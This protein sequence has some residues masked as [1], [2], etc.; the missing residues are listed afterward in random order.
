MTNAYDDPHLARLYDHLNTWGP[1]DE[2]YLSLIRGARA[3]LDVGCGTGTP[4]HRTRAE[5]HT[6]R[7]VGLDPAAAMLDRARVRT[8]IEWVHGDL[9]T[10]DWKEEF[11]LAVMTGHA[12]QELPSDEETVTA[13]AAVRRA[14][15]PGGVFA[16][17]TRT[18]ATRDWESWTPDHPLH[19]RD[20]DGAPLTQVHEATP[21]DTQGLVSL[22]T[23][24]SGL[25]CRNHAATTGTC[26]TSPP[27]TWTPCWPP[28][29][30]RSRNGSATGTAD[31]TRPPVPRSSPLPVPER[32]TR[33]DRRRDCGAVGTSAVG[34]GPVPGSLRP[35][36]GTPTPP[37]DPARTAPPGC[38]RGRPPGSACPRPRR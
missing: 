24:Y 2:F 31:P 38:R 29:G 34:G 22:T 5:G 25:R 23:T 9:T 16:F 26:G 36:G 30:W 15:V 37:G 32:W 20:P 10:V 12:F 17:E 13:L 3:V 1:D 7:L 21:P 8:D 14:L 6:G 19:S 18:P 4:L 35:S 33:Y 27:S 28:P 11:D